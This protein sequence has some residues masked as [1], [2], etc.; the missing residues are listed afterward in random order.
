MEEFEKQ[1]EAELG[2]ARKRLEI[3]SQTQFKKIGNK[4]A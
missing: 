2:F 3:E 4:A 1:H